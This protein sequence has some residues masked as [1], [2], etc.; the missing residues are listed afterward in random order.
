MALV[1]EQ[2]RKRLQL[3]LVRSLVA[4]HK[5]ALCVASPGPHVRQVLI[6]LMCNGLERTFEDLIVRHRGL[7]DDGSEDAKLKLWV[8][9]Q[10][11]HVTQSLDTFHRRH[12][13]PV[14]LGC[15]HRRSMEL[16]G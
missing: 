16:D 12:T 8:A 6:E 1:L 4:N 7:L 9:E 14:V 11:Q 13:G 2:S 3:L 10:G 15:V 5:A